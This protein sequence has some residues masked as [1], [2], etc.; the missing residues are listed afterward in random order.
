MERLPRFS[1]R[2]VDAV[3]AEFRRVGA[4]LVARAGA[5]DLDHL[6]ARFGE[7]QRRERAGEE[8]AEIEDA[9]ACER[10]HVVTEPLRY[11]VHR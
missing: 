4:H 1:M 7:E 10:L 6:R 8:G 11:G 2:E 9:Y 5:L 3:R